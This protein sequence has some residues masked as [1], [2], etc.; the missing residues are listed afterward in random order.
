[1][2]FIM[3]LVGFVT[4]VIS[5]IGLCVI[6]FGKNTSFPIYISKARSC[7]ARFNSKS[8]NFDNLGMVVGWIVV[9]G[10]DLASHVDVL[11]MSVI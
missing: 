5:K 10:I 3:I 1:M 6:S 4:E 7:M 9:D 2:P 8:I 11:I